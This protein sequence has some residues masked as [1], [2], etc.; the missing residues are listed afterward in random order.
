M[1]LAARDQ[2]WE[3]VAE[4]GRELAERRRARQAPAIASIDAARAKRE[5]G[6]S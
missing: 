2:R 5:R 3:V 1:A 4:L 6:Q